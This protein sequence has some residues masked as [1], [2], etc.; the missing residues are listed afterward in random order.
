MLAVDMSHWGGAL[1]DA[2]AQCLKASGYSKI[3][4]NSYGREARGQLETGQRAG[5]GLEIY[6][7]LYW[8]HDNV[9]RVRQAEVMANGLPIGRHW[10][11][12][13]DG[14]VPPDF[15]TQYQ[16]AVDA[17]GLPVGVYTG[18]WWWPQTGNS[19]RF[20]HLPL[21]VAKYSG[22]PT[23]ADCP[24]LVPG[25][26]PSMKQFGGTQ[27]VC[28]QSVDV[29]Y[30]EEEPMPI[31]ETRSR[32]QR[33]TAAQRD[34]I[35]TVYAKMVSQHPIES[36]LVGEPFFD[37]LE[38]LLAPQWRAAWLFLGA[39]PPPPMPEYSGGALVAPRRPD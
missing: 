35:M 24:D 8:D 25:W 31:E 7:Y 17:A 5:L 14:P 28:G 3:I 19:R 38:S 39:D 23:L 12:A 11:D 37:S 13:E 36:A 20:I 27:L 4:V 1:T 9:R 30:Y 21:W 18:Y 10:L 33:F 32:R 22:G 6:T 16:Q 15:E 34:A 29:N 26:K 2:E